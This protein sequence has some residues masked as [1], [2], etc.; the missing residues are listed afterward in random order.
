MSNFM[1]F[2]SDRANVYLILLD[3]SGSMEN[4]TENV[5]TGFRMYKKS[6]ENFPEAN[7][8]AV[9]VCKFANG[10]GPGEFRL[11]KDLNFSYRPNGGTALNYSIVK[12]KEYLQDYVRE[13]TE[14]KGVIP[15]VTFI[16]FSD[17]SPCGDP[18]SPSEGKKA[19]ADMN[20]AGYT[21][22]FVAFGEGIDSNFGKKM[23]FMSTVDVNDKETLP[24]FLGETLSQSCK[25]QSKSLKALGANFFSQA[26][27]K[28]QSEGYSQATTQALEDTSWIDEI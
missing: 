25:E 17:G 11:V 24:T 2:S 23:G 19:I 28:T 14:S 3:E 5:L 26:A 22:V 20:Y 12:A 15:R 21:T 6:F 1:N 10:F 13:I 9:S 8:I 18:M 7:S 27:D 16:L 4:D